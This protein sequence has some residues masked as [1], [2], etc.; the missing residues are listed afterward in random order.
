[1]SSNQWLKDNPEKVR[2]YKKKYY[3][4]NKSKVI[5]ESNARKQD[6]KRWADDLKSSLKCALCPENDIVCL[7][8]HHTNP[9]EKDMAIARA[10]SYGV[11]KARILAEM[12]KCKVLCANCHRKVHAGKMRV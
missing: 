7:D 2:A 12:K 8:F 10:V 6:L 3:L 4:A 1:M 5:A 11:S 9:D